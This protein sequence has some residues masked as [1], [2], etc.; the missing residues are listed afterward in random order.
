M[1]WGGGG[2]G[3]GFRLWIKEIQI[4]EGPLIFMNGN[5]PFR[6]FVISRGVGQDRSV[7]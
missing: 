4:S 7:M 6:E 2:G 3:G 1:A 5:F